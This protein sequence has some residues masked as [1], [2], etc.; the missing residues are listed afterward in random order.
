[1]RTKTLLLTAAITAAGLAS[2]MAQAVY[3]VNMV[4]YINLSIP[5]GYSMIA[6]QLQGAS[7]TLDALFPTAPEGAGVFKLRPP[8]ATGYDSAEVVGGAWEYTGPTLSL[9]PG[10]GGWFFNPGTTAYV[11]TLV[12]EVVLTSNNQIAG[13]YSIKST[14][15]PQEAGVSTV[16]L[17]P[18]TTEGTG[19]F[20]KKLVGAGYDSYEIV[21]GAWEPAEPAPRVGESFWVFNPGAQMAWS[22]TFPVGP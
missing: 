17:F 12:G 3:S 11:P 22:R 2:S 19:I 21:G 6:N 5:P 7:S 18:T 16:H 13:G 9:A 4:G 8:P 1:M 10:E 15:I 14:V 20:R